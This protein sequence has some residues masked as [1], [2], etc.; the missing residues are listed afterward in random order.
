M[1]GAEYEW[2][3]NINGTGSVQVEGAR[4]KLEDVRM[5]EA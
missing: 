3:K 5:A 2:E 4:Y 1:G